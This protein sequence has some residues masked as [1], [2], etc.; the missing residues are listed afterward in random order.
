MPGSSKDYVAA[1]CHKAK[2]IESSNW[3]IPLFMCLSNSFL[4]LCIGSIT[5][6]PLKDRILDSHAGTGP[7]PSVGE[8]HDHLSWLW[9]RIAP[10]PEKVTDPWRKSLPDDG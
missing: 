8:F 5:H 2:S 10:E 7:F 3:Y 4:C 9:R 6:G 1:A